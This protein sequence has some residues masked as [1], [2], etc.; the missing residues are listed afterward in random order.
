MRFHPEVT[1]RDQ[2]LAFQPVIGHSR[3]GRQRPGQA[4]IAFGAQRGQDRLAE[5]RPQDQQVT[6]L[7]RTRRHCLR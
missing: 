5:A 2:A 3:L 6:P 4:P 7:V 1:Y